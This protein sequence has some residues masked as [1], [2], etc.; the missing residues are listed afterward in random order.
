[1]LDGKEWTALA[2]AATI[3][4]APLAAAAIGA[5]I[6]GTAETIDEISQRQATQP[7][8]IRN[9]PPTT[10]STGTLTP[11]QVAPGQ[12]APRQ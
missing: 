9:D 7:A 4:I 11:G 10:G 5:R 1:M 2:L 8:P 12:V 3:L 6:T